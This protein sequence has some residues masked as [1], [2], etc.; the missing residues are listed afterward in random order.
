MLQRPKKNLPRTLPVL[1][2]LLLLGGCTGISIAPSCPNE[3]EVG[4]SGVVAANVINP[5]AIPEYQWT[6]NPA[7]AGTFE[8]SDNPITRFTASKTGEVSIT[9]TAGDGLYLVQSSCHITVISDNGNPPGTEGVSVSLSWNPVSP[10]TGQPV[11]VTCNST[12]QT[13]ATSFELTRTAGLDVAVTPLG[14]RSLVFTASEA[15][16]V[17]F[18]CIGTADNGTE[19]EPTSITLTITDP[20]GGGRPPR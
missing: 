3:L 20:S 6:A 8:D 10:E 17:T 12:G 13:P 7:D 4:A 5:G 9:L 18:Q 14:S 19:S 15:G 2:A 11:T 1:G 16:T